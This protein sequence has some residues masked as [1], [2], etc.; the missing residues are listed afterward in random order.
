MNA[1]TK[2]PVLTAEQEARAEVLIKHSNSGFYARFFQKNGRN[3]TD[4]EV[5]EFSKKNVASITAS[6][7]KANPANDKT[8]RKARIEAVNELAAENGIKFFHRRATAVEL[9]KGN[10]GYDYLH[11]VDATRGGETIAFK[12][13][14]GNGNELFMEYATAFCRPDEN[15]DPLIGKE[16]SIKK[17][18]RGDVLSTQIAHEKFGEVKL[19]Q[20]ISLYKMNEVAAQAAEAAITPTEPARAGVIA[21]EDSDT[22]V[23]STGVAEVQELSA[24][25]LAQAI[26]AQ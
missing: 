14:L 18:L 26:P 22:L 13:F 10:G 1:S 7:L 17:F 12:Y 16:E 11:E 4:A 2:N 6:I 20:L 8:L 5:Q 15:F 24:P 23:P 21:L 25:A 9:E 3:P 19:E